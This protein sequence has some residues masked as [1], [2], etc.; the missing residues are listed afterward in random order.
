MLKKD[1]TL[2]RDWKKAREPD[3]RRAIYT[4]ECLRCGGMHTFELNGSYTGGHGCAS[5]CYLCDWVGQ[6]FSPRREYLG[7]PLE[8]WTHSL[9]VVKRIYEMK[10]HYERDVQATM[11]RVRQKERDSDA[12]EWLLTKG[13]KRV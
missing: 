1:E 8:K 4:V 5:T 12:A 10:E 6:E 2:K 13:W 7:H 3:R 11:D 9:H